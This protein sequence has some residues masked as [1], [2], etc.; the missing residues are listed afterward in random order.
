MSKFLAVR[1][2]AFGAYHYPHSHEPARSNV[3][4]AAL[5]IVF[6]SLIGSFAALNLGFM[7]SGVLRLQGK[8]QG[9]ARPPGLMD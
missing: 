1:Y 5:F 6:C 3:L 4:I 9:R 7:T 2:V 8:H